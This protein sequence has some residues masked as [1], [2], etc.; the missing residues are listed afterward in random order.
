YLS[1]LELGETLQAPLAKKAKIKRTTLRELLPDLFKRGILQQKVNGKRKYLIARD[2]R[3]LIA[4]LEEKTKRAKEVLPQF[5]ALQKVITNK[6]EVRFFEGI[7]GLKQ[8]YQLTLDVGLTMYCF[9]NA[10]QM[11]PEFRTWVAQYYIPE[12]LR[13]KIWIYNIMTSGE[14][15]KSL[16]PE[17]G[18]RENKYI[19]KEQYP[20]DMEIV[21][22][23]DYVTFHHFRQSDEPSAILIKSKAA[24]ETMLSIH[25]LIWN[26]IK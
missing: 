22:F 12:K 23:G 10:E 14:E 2:P 25:Q 24:A 16:M 19:S 7:E 1:A 4:E 9:V 6:P 3:E 5:L 21:V 20:F 26:N 11:Y 17:H 18:F 8:I 15:T 13:R